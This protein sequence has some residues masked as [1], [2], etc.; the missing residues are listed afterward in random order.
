[1]PPPTPPRSC[2]QAV[3][4]RQTAA[5]TDPTSGAAIDPTGAVPETTPTVTTPAD[6]ATPIDPN[7][8]V[9]EPELRFFAPRVDVTFGEL[10]DTKQIDNVRYFDFL[11][12]EETPVAAFLGLGESADKA[13]FALSNEVIESSG[14]GSCS[15][16]NSD[17]CDL[18]IMRVG[19]ER[20]LK[21]VDGTTYRLELLDTHFTRI[22]DPRDGDETPADG[23]DQGAKP[24]VTGHY[25]P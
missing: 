23:G 3:R 8:S 22:P 1:M 6:P 7:Q 14:E 25:Q 12:D 10:G 19:Q 20:M 15:P 13:V 11:P 21:L 9:T 16:H 4:P 18:L 24:V 5:L 2:R 17:G